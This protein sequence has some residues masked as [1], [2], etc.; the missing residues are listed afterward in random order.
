MKRL[1]TC[2]AAAV[3]A[4]LQ[5]GW[6][7]QDQGFDPLAVV[8]TYH[9]VT[10]EPLDFQ[11]V[12]GQTDAAK[13]AW[14]FD[15]EGVL[16]AE[17]ARL[18]QQMAASSGATEFV[19]GVDDTLSQ[20]DH[21]LGEFVIE[22][23]APGAYVPV[24]VFHLDYRLVFANRERARRLPMPKEQAR[25][26]DARM[27]RT[28]RQ[29]VD[30]IRF[31]VVGKGDPS[32]G[33]AGS[34]I[35]AEIVSLR[36]LDRNGNVIVIPDMSKESA[37]E[38]NE[39]SFDAAKV[40]VAGLRL[41]VSASDLEAALTRL[42]GSATRGKAAG[43]NW[44]KF[45]GSVETNPNGCYSVYGRRTNPGPGT[46]CITAPFDD[47][48]VIRA[49][50]IERFFAPFD[51]DILIKTMV[52]K[53]GPASSNRGT[54]L[55]WGPDVA[56]AGRALT[57]LYGEDRQLFDEGLGRVPNVKVTLQLVDPVWAAANSR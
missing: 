16:K 10:G 53:H 30:E 51:P 9:K 27:N 29:I 17:V 55:G 33:V 25:E 31:K 2:T 1:L 36:V 3:V 41:G 8:L 42:Y 26:F 48:E 4:L 57:A 39:R 28:G 32:G 54:V 45:A 18:Q 11:A 14:G 21:D 43:Y 6:A 35:R 20:Y 5:A 40:D 37:A 44:A 23:F 19:I 24:R 50:R 49:I 15:Y 22:L 38:E 13:R 12:A 46:V 56:G 52:K 47:K 34:V 7:Q